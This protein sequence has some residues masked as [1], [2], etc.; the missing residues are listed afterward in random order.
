MVAKRGGSHKRSVECIKTF[1]TVL[2]TLKFGATIP[3]IEDRTGLGRRQVI[4]WIGIVEDVFGEVERTVPRKG[5][6]FYRL[7][8]DKIREKF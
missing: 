8:R 7:D 1:I 3:E 2:R 6:W 5:K 4:R